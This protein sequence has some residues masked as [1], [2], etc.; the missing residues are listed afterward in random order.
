MDGDG[1]GADTSPTPKQECKSRSDESN[2]TEEEADKIALPQ[3]KKANDRPR[4]VKRALAPEGDP[5]GSPTTRSRRRQTLSSEAPTET[6]EGAVSK[7]R[8]IRRLQQELAEQKHQMQSQAIIAKK[9]R[10]LLAQSL[11]E[12]AKSE[13]EK[14]RTRLFHESYRVGVQRRSPV[15]QSDGWEGGTE[16]AAIAQLKAKLRRERELVESDRRSVQRQMKK[17]METEDAENAPNTDDPDEFMETREVCNHRAEY[18]R[19]EEAALKDREHR[20]MA[21][22]TLFQ[23]HEMLANTQ[24]RSRFKHYPMLQERFQ[25]LNVIGKG[26]QSEIYKAFDLEQ[27]CFCAIKIHETETKISDQQAR[28]LAYRAVQELKIHKTLQ[29]S[30]IVQLREYFQIDTSASTVFAMVLELCEGETLD[31]RLKM[32]GPMPEK[33]AK[34]IIVQI[35]NGLRY[36]NSA[37]RKIIHYDIKPSNLFYNAGQVKLGDFGLSKIADSP[38]GMIDLSSLGAGTSWYLPPECHEMTSPTVNSKVDVWST[39]VVFFELL[40][41]R[42]P[43]GEGQTQDAFR[44]QTAVEGT[45]DIVFPA[46]PK[47]SA[48][49]IKFLRRLLTRDRDQRPDVLEAIRDPYIRKTWTDQSARARK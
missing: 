26:G 43:F 21:D 34:S 19:R 49:A 10:D 11:I 5:S 48:E 47:V 15:G 44:R 6:E 8:E 4:G 38:E 7:D 29:H 42:R 37:G 36:L 32:H 13:R 45:F 14:E 39:G 16:A 33:E 3:P 22:R 31:M 18:I 24:E 30:R 12:I 46:S 1:A 23:K 27:M 28:Y 2:G 9:G 35:L 40:F 17:A 41:N 20:L 25:L